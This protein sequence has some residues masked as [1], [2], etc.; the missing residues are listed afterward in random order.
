MQLL[1]TLFSA[2]ID[3]LQ[4]EKEQGPK[5][6]RGSWEWHRFQTDALAAGG[7]TETPKE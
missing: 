4:T 6:S 3:V 7:K 2:D 5:E 1:V